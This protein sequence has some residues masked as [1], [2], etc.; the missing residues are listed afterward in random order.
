MK[1]DCLFCK[2]VQHELPSVDI[3]ED[4]KVIAFMSLENHPL[5][6]P[7]CHFSDVYE[8]DEEYAAAIMQAT[9]KIAKATRKAMNCHGINLVQSNGKI[10]G[11]DVFHF[12]LHIKPRFENDDVILSWN[13]ETVSNKERAELG[14]KIK[15]ALA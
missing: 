6:V 9:V 2:I 7:K 12:H 14:V 1:T 15:D 5:I 13:T 11:Q 8:L 10:A 4:D 3:Y